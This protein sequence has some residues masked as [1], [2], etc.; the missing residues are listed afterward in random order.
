MT[1]AREESRSR[2]QR[3]HRKRLI[4]PR[5]IAPDNLEIYQ[6]QRAAAEKQRQR[7]HQ[8]LRVRLLI[9][10]EPVRE[11][12]TRRAEGRVPRRNRA[13]DDAEHREHRADRAEQR[14]A[15]VVDERRLP[16]EAR[17]RLPQPARAVVDRHARRGP[18]E[19]DN[20]LRD[21]RAVK[22]LAPLVLVTN[23]ARHHRRLRRVEARDGSAGDRDEHQRPDRQ[24]LRMQIPEAVPHLRHLVALRHHTAADAKAHDN[25]R[26]AEKRIEPP[27][28]FIDRQKRRE[29]IVDENDREPEMHVERLRRQQSEKPRGAD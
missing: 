21:H 12:Q 26:R 27:D 6:R 8:P 28:D 9:D 24:P 19:R 10:A 23:T 25:Q 17:R 13:D 20:A 18:D 3:N 2:P 5:E 11:R 22:D 7:E 4:R 29:E 1:H 15:D 14:V 16:G